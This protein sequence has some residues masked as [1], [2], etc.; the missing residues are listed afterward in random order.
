MLSASDQ[1]RLPNWL[2]PDAKDA[3]QIFYTLAA[4]REL[5]YMIQRLA[6]REMMKDAWAELEHFEGV[7]PGILIALTITTWLSAT[8]SLSLGPG[9][10]PSKGLSAHDLATQSRNVTDKMRA[11]HQ[12]IRAEAGV[13]DT[14]LTELNRVAVFLEREAACVDQL[15]TIVPLPRKARARNAHHIAFVNYMCGR[16]WQPIRRRPYK[17]VATLTNVAFDVQGWHAD[18]VKHCYRSRAVASEKGN[19]KEFF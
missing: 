11:V 5:R 9:S 12:T 15:V 8:R 10:A 3:W 1:V 19:I 17:L 16:L 2:P 18:R 7:T 4:E 13:T 14:T 6:R